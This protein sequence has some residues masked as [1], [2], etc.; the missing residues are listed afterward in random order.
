VYLHCDN[1]FENPMMKSV[2][3]YLQISSCQM[4]CGSFL[5]GTKMSRPTRPLEESSVA[6]LL[7]CH[8]KKLER[9]AWASSGSF[10]RYSSKPNTDLASQT[11]TL[12]NQFHQNSASASLSR[13]TLSMY[14]PAP[15]ICNIRQQARWIAR[16][17]GIGG[18][19]VWSGIIKRAGVIGSRGRNTRNGS[20]L[21]IVYVWSTPG[22]A[23]KYICRLPNRR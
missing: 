14:S 22:V 23:S 20:V 16:R 10:R 13:R 1:Y 3:H 12:R 4:G 21:L 15:L 8:V 19:I 9:V 11:S 7:A 18:S 17:R 2:Q 5:C 6:L